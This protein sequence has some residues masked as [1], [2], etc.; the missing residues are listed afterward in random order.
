MIHEGAQTILVFQYFK[1][2]HKWRAKISRNDK[3]QMASQILL[4]FMTLES[5]NYLLP[6]LGETSI[7]LNP[8]FG[9]VQVVDLF[10]A[11]KIGTKI[12][13]NKQLTNHLKKF[14][15]AEEMVSGT[16]SKKMATWS[17]GMVFLKIMVSQFH[18]SVN[19]A[20]VD[21]GNLSTMFKYL[22]SLGFPSIY[23]PILEL[24]FS[25]ERD[26]FH[27]WQLVNEEP[28]NKC[29]ESDISL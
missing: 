18:L 23:E 14:C 22:K 25:Q 10:F 9:H 27:L 2:F 8:N 4:A 13:R 11:C 19:W 3:I 6:K 5:Y 20:S 28:L 1:S 21:K 7:A 12:S 24:M 17:F 26:R 29:F 15:T 16:F